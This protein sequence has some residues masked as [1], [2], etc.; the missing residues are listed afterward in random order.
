LVTASRSDLTS[1]ISW[2]YCMYTARFYG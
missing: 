1:H 2:R